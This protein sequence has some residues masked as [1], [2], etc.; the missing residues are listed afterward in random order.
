MTARALRLTNWDADLSDAAGAIRIAADAVNEEASH[1]DCFFHFIEIAK[2]KLSQNNALSRA[3]NET[4]SDLLAAI[5]TLAAFDDLSFD[6]ALPL[7]KQYFAL[8]PG[9]PQSLISVNATGAEYLGKCV[10]DSPSLPPPSPRARPV[11]PPPPDKFALPF[12]VGPPTKKTIHPRVSS[13]LSCGSSME[14]ISQAGTLS[15]L[16]Q[17]TPTER[18]IS[19]AR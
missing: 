1:S 4:R 16:R 5:Y 15:M 6:V 2:A 7:L 12:N 3:V 19:R 14:M 8:R 10:C 13:S 9:G 18:C 17:S 11:H